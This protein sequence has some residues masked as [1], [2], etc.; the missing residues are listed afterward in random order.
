MAYP[1]GTTYP[2]TELL[3]NGVWTDYSARNRAP[4]GTTGVQ[5]TRG[6]ANE[7]GQVTAQTSSFQLNTRDGLFSTRN[8]NSALF[9]LIPRN[10]Q[11]RHRAGDGDNYLF[12]PWNDQPGFND[13]LTSDKALL[14][15]LGDMEV[16]VDIWPHQWQLPGVTTMVIAGKY[17][18]TANQKSWLLWLNYDGT[19]QFRTS[20]DGSTNVTFAS[21]VPVPVTSTR[22]SIKV[23][24]DVDNGAAGKTVQFF[25]APSINGTYTQL[26]ATVT[27]A[28]ITS[29]FNSTAAMSIGTAADA[30]AFASGY[31][32]GGKF[33]E[34]QVR[35][36]IGGTLVANPVWGSAALGA[37]S[38]ADG[39]G[40]T[41][42]LNNKARVISD[43]V[44]YVGELNIPA[45]QWDQTGRDVFATVNSAGIISRLQANGQTIGS[46]M[47]RQFRQ[48]SGA[49]GFW[50]MEDL[51]GS[52]S[53]STPIVGASAAII[54]TQITMGGSDSI[55]FPGS[56]GYAAFGDPVSQPQIIIRPKFVA[57]TQTLFA[58]FSV[59]CDSFATNAATIASFYTTGGTVR[60]IDVIVDP[61]SPGKW[62]VSLIAVD[63]STLATGTWNMDTPPV[64]IDPRQ[65]WI[66]VNLLCT[67]S[68]GTVSW[69]VRWFAYGDTA[70]EGVGF[71]TFA[72]SLGS[73]DSARFTNRNSTGVSGLK[74]SQVYL[75]NVD[76]NFVSTTVFNATNAY[77]GETAAVRIDRLGNEEA[78]TTEIIGQW[79]RSA[80]MGAQLPDTFMNLVQ[81]CAIADRGI[82]SESRSMLAVEYRCGA[83]LEFHRDATIN[84]HPN[85]E[86]TSITPSE[87]GQGFANDVTI[88]R[89]QGSSARKV[90]TTSGYRQIG[91]AAPPAGA[92]TVTGAGPGGGVVNVQKDTQLPDLAGWYAHIGSWDDARYPQFVMSLHR[93]EVKASTTLP[94]QIRG[95]DLG[96][97]A[98]LTS[99]PS[100]LPPESIL[101]L[102]Q[103]YTE[104]LT[105]FLWDISFNATPGSAYRTGRY[106]TTDV[107]GI[108]RYTTTG[109]TVST[110]VNTTATTLVL[111]YSTTGDNWTVTSGSYPF[112]LMIEGERITLTAPPA[113]STSPQ[114]FTGVTRSVNGIVKAH[115][116][117]ARVDLFDTCY[118][119]V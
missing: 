24:I 112:D 19:L 82:L 4:G 60:R 102:V 99:P 109:S 119:A 111:A 26:G 113:G 23:T 84:Y 31:T 65:R 94:Q 83:D 15:V 7:Q 48:L 101:L 8:P 80:L 22:L 96:D 66:S 63:G 36:S 9:G 2:I 16:R 62:T 106:D 110:A 46:A 77:A 1:D 35:S 86:L 47:T 71:F 61:T 58:M 74:L 40:N 21:T 53:A 27:T 33:Y 5:I 34:L 55:N 14:D 32:F 6:R 117:G 107:A 43:R 114:T 49:V 116:V 90:I 81:E 56:A 67:A 51:A 104:T 89:K 52:Q 93:S 38:L 41:W 42:A 76:N 98:T 118:Y 91:T 50:P 11:V 12:I 44:R 85:A 59:R 105:H 97:T 95:L 17:A 25:T 39:L 72:G 54:D 88:A 78:I 20:P 92:G 75:S 68:A 37:T 30:P 13:A 10:T 87:D 29:I 79:S 64:A 115:G 70:F 103:G 18:S 3:I 73:W 28:G 100:F 57:S 45:L 69:A 108:P